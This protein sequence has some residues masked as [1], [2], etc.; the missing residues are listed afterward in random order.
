MLKQRFVLY[1]TTAGDVIALED[2]CPHRGAALSLGKLENDCLRCPYHGWAFDAGG[3]C[4]DIPSLGQ[5]AI[6]PPKARVKTYPVHEKYGYV[7]LFYGDLATAESV[8]LPTLPESIFSTMY[9]VSH[10]CI[11]PASYTRLMQA[12]LDFAHVIAVHK[13]SFGQRIPIK[14]PI[15]YSVQ[16]DDRSAA[17]SVKY[18]ALDSSKNLLNRI[19]GSRPDLTTRLSFYLPNITLAEISIGRGKTTDIQFAILV[20]FVPINEY[21]TYAKR[22]LYRNVLPFRL[23]DPWVRKL[24]FKLANED[25]VVVE[26]ILNQFM[27]SISHELHVAADKL[28]LTFRNMYQRY[29]AKERTLPA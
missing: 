26:T 13:S 2:Q 12:N 19:L 24:D 22:F 16:Q 29:S 11:E 23:I 6:L 10:E 17:A 27:P 21:A 8:P 28:D 20:A 3:Y 1:R 5:D 15:H 25:T 4:T 9:P 7:W 18:N 14:T